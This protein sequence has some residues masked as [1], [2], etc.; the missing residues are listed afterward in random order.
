MIL[1]MFS[2]L[3]HRV[4]FIGGLFFM[5]NGI[6]FIAM[7]LLVAGFAMAQDVVVTVNL[8]SAE[9]VGKEIGTITAK[10][11]QFGVLLTPNLA[12]LPPGVHGFHLH[13]NASCEPAKKDE[14]MTA[15]QAAGAHLDP[16]KTA[17]HEG[18]YAAG[19]VGDLPPLYAGA[20]GNVTTPVLAPRLKAKDLKG[21]ALM[22]HAGGDNFS[23]K[24]EALGGGGA[25]I[26]CG[27][28][29]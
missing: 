21:H 20:D 5:K 26:A 2:N 3:L 18:P 7:L 15:A 10:D 22:I 4:S 9:G 14:K 24:P 28:V 29:K 1:L 19:H 25:R 23:D 8:V 11:T 12:G 17:K 27:V 13:E 6:L 16:G